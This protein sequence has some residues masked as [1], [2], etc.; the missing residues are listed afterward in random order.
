[1]KNL[2]KDVFNSNIEPSIEH[3]I[4]VSINTTND[5]LDKAISTN[6]ATINGIV[7][8]INQ[9]QYKVDNLPQSSASFGIADNDEMLDKL[10]NE[11]AERSQR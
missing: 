2:L 4:K 5:D 6:T 3:S 9:L 8:Q 10:V 7:S 1:M 11:S